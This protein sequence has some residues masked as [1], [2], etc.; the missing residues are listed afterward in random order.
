[1]VN[2]FCQGHDAGQD[3]LGRVWR[4]GGAVVRPEARPA[5]TRGR[6][7]QIVLAAMAWLGLAAAGAGQSPA[8]HFPHAVGMPPGAI[9]AQQLGR[10]G[11]VVGYFQPVEIAAPDGAMV[12]M[13]EG[14]TLGEPQK[15]PVRVGLLIGQVYRFCVFN[16]PFHAG[17]EVFP[18][19]EVV[20]RLY[21]PP[22]QETRFPIK[23]ELTLDDLR[24]A[25]DGKFVTR[26][27]YLEDPE[28]ALPVAAGGR[29]QSWFEVPPGRDPL[30]VADA[31]GRPVAIVRMGGRMPDHRQGFDPQFL[32]GCPPLLKYPPPASVNPPQPAAREPG[33]RLTVL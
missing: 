17:Q 33:P 11:P 3:A 5:G 15:A 4:T 32:F 6:V 30:V 16:I 26:V 2:E 10:G 23:I 31:L 13:A 9:G 22:G 27:V 1:M 29:P 24:L 28:R 12:A 7:R 19:I 14:G 18:T 21:T 25:M 8:L 20:D